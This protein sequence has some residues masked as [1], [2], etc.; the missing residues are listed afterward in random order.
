MTAP[1]TTASFVPDDRLARRNALV[2][3]TA[4]ALAGA[5][6]M[7]IIGTVGIA[8]GSFADK[9]LVTLPVTFFVLGM[10]AGTL[11]VGAIS[12]RYGRRVAYL[13][14][15]GFGMLAGLVLTFAIIKASLALLCVGATF[16]GLYGACAQSYRF[17]AADTA[18]EGFKPK[19][20]SWVMA[21]GIMA[22]FFGPQLIILTKD[23][24]APYLFAASYVAQALVAVA[25]AIVLLFLRIPVP[26]RAATRAGEGRPLPEIFRQPKLL[27]AVACG[28]VSY[29]M[30]NLVMTSAPVAM[31]DCG[32]S[33][34]DATLGLQWH[35][36]AMFAPSFFTGSLIVRFGVEKVIGFGLALLA[37]AGVVGWSGITVAHFWAALI[38]LGLGWNFSFVGATALVTECHRPNERNKVQAVNDFLVFG[39]M[40]IGSFSSGKLLANYGWPAVNEVV[41]P[42]VAVAGMLLIWQTLA[43]RRAEA[44]A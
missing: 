19:A 36:I 10:W 2:L 14:G 32:H 4:Q 11:P 33:I 23:I 40:A 9:A 22:G 37:A 13:I 34:T 16:A 18:S 5:N 38:L 29:S 1:H 3:G 43:R 28:V 26:P 42:L 7:T 39:S 12:R 30:M 35:V 17:A 31:V 41:L 6:A 24:G 21:G 44:A 8:A 25:A 20:I 15:A 27:V